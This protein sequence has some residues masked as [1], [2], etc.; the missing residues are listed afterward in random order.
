M[1]NILK[2]MG[3]LFVGLLYFT[4]LISIIFIANGVCVCACMCVCVCVGGG[5]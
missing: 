1:W 3:V 4:H 5:M 2:N